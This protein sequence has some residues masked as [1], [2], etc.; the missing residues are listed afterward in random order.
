MKKKKEFELGDIIKKLK[1]GK[2]AKEIADEFNI[3]KSNL[4]YYLAKLKKQGAIRYKG[5]GIWQVQKSVPTQSPDKK[6]IRGHAFIWKIE[7][8]K[9]IDW[10]KKLK[11][12]KIDY[13]TQSN[14]HVFRIFFLGKKVWLT[15]KGMIIYEPYDFWGKSSYESKGKA[16]FNLDRY[17]KN[18]FF[19]LKIKPIPYQFTTSRE[20]FAKVKDEMAR[21]YNNNGEKLYVRRDDGTAWMWIDFSH[22]VHETEND[23]IPDSRGIQV[24]L[25]DKKKNNYKVTDS[26]VLEGFKETNNM[27][28]KVTQNQ[29]M[30]AKNIESHIKS[31]QQLGNSA[32]ANSVSAEL[33]A[34]TIKEMKDSFIHQIEELKSEIRELKNH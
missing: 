31:V 24:Y 27:I 11:Q 3:S 2:K 8:N 25:N 23:N 21:Q 15:K 29:Q 28:S 33:L 16:V 14:G 9:K 22:G 13:K 10:E 19:K 12:S 6:Q 30:F 5:F 34:G 32:E 20:H 1:E 26:F 4:S 7:F 17:I 18:L